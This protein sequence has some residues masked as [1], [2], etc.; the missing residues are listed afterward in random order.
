MKTIEVTVTRTINGPPDQVY[1]VWLDAKSPGGP[2]SGAER[3]LL[4]AVVDGLFFISMKHQASRSRPHY[5]RFIRLERGRTIEHTWMSESTHGL[6]TTVTITLT[7]RD[8][9]TELVLRHVG[10]PDDDDGRGHERGWNWFGSRVAER[11]PR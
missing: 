4:N 11:F 5:G 3:V 10:L 9:K 1:D 7:P 2:W 6:E 8:G